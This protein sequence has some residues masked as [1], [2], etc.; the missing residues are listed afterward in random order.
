ML[1]HYFFVEGG[2]QVKSPQYA[3]PQLP[4]LERRIEDMRK[5]ILAHLVHPE[6]PR[7]ERVIGRSV[8]R[9]EFIT[10]SRRSFLRSLTDYQHQYILKIK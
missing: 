10:P 4:N 2:D 7:E 5:E 3:E 8:L 1:S 9:D 6:T